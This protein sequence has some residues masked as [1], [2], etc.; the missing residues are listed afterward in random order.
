MTTEERCPT[1]LLADLRAEKD[2]FGSHERVA[3]SIAE[4]VQTEDGGRTIGLEGDWGAGKSTIV[5][6]TSKKLTQNGDCDHK[7]SVFDIWAHQDDPL[8]RTF[9]EKLITS[10]QEYGW[11]NKKEW[12]RRKAELTGRRREDKTTVSPKLTPIGKIFALTLLSIPFGAALISAGA[13]LLASEHG[14][15]TWAAVLFVLGGIA[16]LATG[17]FYGF[18][19]DKIPARGRRG[20][21][22]G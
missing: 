11:V 3:Q 22:R 7:V 5:R 9:L 15:G 12:D 16:L 8:R 17:I 20:G 2:A 19:Q 1:R 18:L 4:I 13:T 6:L 21:W 14:S 10:F